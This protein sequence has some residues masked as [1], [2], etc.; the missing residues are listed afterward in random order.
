MLKLLRFEF[1]RIIKSVFFWIVAAYSFVWPVLTALFYAALMSLDLE[2]G[3]KFNPINI[4][5]D[6]V[7]FLTWMLSVAFIT[8]LPK[9]VAL[10]TCLHLGRD[11]TDGIVRNKIIAGHSRG[12]IYGSYMITQIAASVF[13]C[14]V[15][16]FSSMFG[17][18]VSGIGVGVNGGEMFARFGVAIV[19]F[20]VMTVSFVV[21]SLIFRR[22]ALPVIL[23]ILIAIMS[24]AAAAVIGS[25]NTP[26]KAVD[27]YIRVRHENYEEMIEAGMLDEDDVEDLEDEYDKDSF[28]GVAWK[29]FHPVYVVSPIGFE[30]D[31]QAGGVTSLVSGSAEYADEIDFSVNFIMQSMYSGD[32]SSVTPHDL[33]KVDSM[34]L[35]YAENNLIYIGKS[36]AWMAVIGAWGF[37]IFR[38]KNLF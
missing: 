17:L 37:V 9:F 32:M 22:R 36:V 28:L 33:K 14:I 30:G 31:Y 21:L 25:F 38:R 29:I 3:I 27:D 11:Y 12:E 18:W 8:E 5:Q 16:I 26:G 10:F 20:L 7:T 13:L 1:R 34:H 4:S 15:Y 35:T 23:C 2:D 6:E 24:N 19:V